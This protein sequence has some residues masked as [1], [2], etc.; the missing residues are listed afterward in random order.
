[1]KTSCPKFLCRLPHVISLYVA[2]TLLF[3]SLNC[4]KQFFR[5]QCHRPGKC[6]FANLLIVHFRDSLFE[7]ELLEVTCVMLPLEVAQLKVSLSR[8]RVDEKLPKLVSLIDIYF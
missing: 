3:L 1:M 7:A 8:D 6:C 2:S 5:K 4:C